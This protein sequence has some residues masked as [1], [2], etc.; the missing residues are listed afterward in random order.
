M[1]E[2]IEIKLTGKQREELE[3][4]VAR[5]S[6]RAQRGDAASTCEFPCQP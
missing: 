6:E 2:L 5:S 3:A 4:I 1:A